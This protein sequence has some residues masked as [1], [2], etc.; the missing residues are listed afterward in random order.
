M[1]S[2]TARGTVTT[3][4]V[5]PAAPVD[6]V[7]TPRSGEPDRTVALEADAAERRRSVRR[8]RSQHQRRV[9]GVVVARCAVEARL[10]VARPQRRLA[11]CTD[12]LVRTPARVAVDS[13]HTR[14]TVQTRTANNQLISVILTL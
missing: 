5:G 2:L 3:R 12:E 10:E 14:A 4:N 6:D 11:V 7:L 8:Q 13:I 1:T 9:G